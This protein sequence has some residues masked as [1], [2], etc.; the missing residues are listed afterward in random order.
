MSGRRYELTDE[1][2]DRVKEY[3]IIPN[4]NGRP[5]KNIRNTVNGIKAVPL[6]EICHPVTVIGM[7]SINVLQNGRKK[8]N[9]RRFSKIWQWRQ[10]YKI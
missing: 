9:L 10:I 8:E 2:W 5:Y 6:G 7:L 3:F 4:K 1:Q